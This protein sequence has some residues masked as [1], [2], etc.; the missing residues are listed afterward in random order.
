MSGVERYRLPL[1]VHLLLVRAGERGREREV[2]LSRRAGQVYAAGMWHLPS[3][4]VD[5]PHEDVVTAVIREAAEET[6]VRIEPG[7]VG[8]AVTVHHRGPQGR[9]RIGLFLQARTWRGSP[10][11]REPDVCDAMGWYPLDA[12]PD[13]MVAYCRAALDAYRAG[14]PGAVHFQEPGDPIL[15]TADA[16]SDRTRLLPGPEQTP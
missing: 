3:G 12:L 11:V 14:L 7:A 15:H 13:P 6:G 16:P 9:A 1:D 5:G 2:L 8:L 4:H 10:R